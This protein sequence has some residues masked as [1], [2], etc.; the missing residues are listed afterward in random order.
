[1]AKLFSE[2]VKEKAVGV[3]MGG[4]DIVENLNEIGIY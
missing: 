4:K 3:K 1:M 2:A